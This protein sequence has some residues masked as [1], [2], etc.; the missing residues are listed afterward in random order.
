MHCPV[1]VKLIKDDLNRDP[2]FTH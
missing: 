2:I 1:N